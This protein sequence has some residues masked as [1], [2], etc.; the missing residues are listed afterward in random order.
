LPHGWLPESIQNYRGIFT[1]YPAAWRASISR[2]HS[3]ASLW[4][5]QELSPG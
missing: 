5:P 3:L 2:C 4:V 1:S